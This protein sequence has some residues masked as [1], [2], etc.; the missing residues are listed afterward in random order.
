MK[1]LLAT[2]IVV[3]LLGTLAVAQA[4]PA[5]LI[6]TYRT[7]STALDRALGLVETSTQQAQ[8]AWT[9]AQNTFRTQSAALGDA[10]L[11]NA[12]LEAFQAGSQSIQSRSV[13][14]AEARVLVIKSI[15]QKAL[16][17]QSLRGLRQTPPEANAIQG[18]QLMV[19]ELGAEAQRVTQITA[20]LN[21]RPIDVAAVR[22]EVDNVAAA[23]VFGS[24]Q[25][26]LRNF[27]DNRT[28]AYLDMVRAY[29]AFI[30]IQ[31]SPQAG[32]LRPNAFINAMSALVE[33]PPRRDEFVS[34][35]N[36]LATRSRE[37]I[38]ATAATP[39]AAVTPQPTPA[40]QP[41]PVPA[42]QPTPTPAAQ[43]TPT[44]AVQPR[45]TP[46]PQPT[47]AV[48]PAAAPLSDDQAAAA[49]VSELTR[50]GVRQ[51]AAG[52]LAARY[53]GAG[54]SGPQAAIE[55]LRAQL[56]EAAVA[57]ETGNVRE[58]QT[59]IRAAQQT[60]LSFVQ[61]VVDA[62]S[63]AIAGRTTDLFRATVESPAPR[64]V[65][66]LVLLGEVG[67]AAAIV[68][69]TAPPGPL[70]EIIVMV[71]SLWAGWPRAG[72]FILIGLLAFYPIRLLGLAFGGGNPY[73]RYIGL[74]LFFLF[75]PAI[76]EALGFIGTL[77][78]TQ[79]EFETL[80]FLAN[81]S[82]LTNTLAQVAWALTLILALV[83]A[84]AG[85]RGIC[86]QFGLLGRRKRE[87]GSF[88]TTS[89]DMEGP[90][91]EAPGAPNQSGETV[92]EWDEEF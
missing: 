54:L 71:Q 85:L 38:T 59:A 58:F 88:A 52:T 70:H 84:I 73:W 69:G 34:Q 55:R 19:R 5:S 81:F 57:A 17:D 79:F 91:K 9:Q 22:R 77:V 42:A 49:I 18:I 8:A 6:D 30:P 63:P 40:V 56:A 76:F 45:P 92:V 48:T 7:L 15:L 46:T 72:V 68:A 87:A 4:Q 89:S 32:A 12:A 53:L 36:A 13:A 37:M 16:L 23:R 25:D 14:D 33:T 65:D 35:V 21:Q 26:A 1:R 2:A 11:V 51:A 3:G 90:A 80:A 60:W 67:E 75:L 64:G 62:S 44:P 47:P 78:A 10:T 82:I 27:S 29:T 28:R 50:A 66:V 86:V 74:A 31:E 24:L 39:T 43:P 41:T 83:F 61:P 20:R